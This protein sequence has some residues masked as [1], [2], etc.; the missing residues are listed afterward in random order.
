MSQPIDHPQS[1]GYAPH[2]DLPPAWPE[3]DA[4][5]KKAPA[6][7]INAL[8]VAAAGA[9]PARD[10]GKKFDAEKDRWDLLPTDAVRGVVRVL[11]FGAKKYGDRNW[12][13]GM[14]W[15]RLYA[16]ALRH[17]TAW[18][19]GETRDPETGHSHLWHAATCIL[20]LCAFELRDAGRDT[21]QRPSA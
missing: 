20:F 21:R 8:R 14:D 16:A 19:E 2:G 12:E 6:D 11:T 10:E 1:D 13:K 4:M 3:G 17:M 18:W 7:A 5:H 9:K 15:G